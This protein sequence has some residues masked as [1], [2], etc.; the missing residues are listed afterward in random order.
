LSASP[1]PQPVYSV[2]GPLGS[3]EHIGVVLAV[4]RRVVEGASR[5]CLLDK[6]RPARALLVSP[7]IFSI[8]RPRPASPP[9]QP[10]HTPSRS[11]LTPSVRPSARLQSLSAFLLS[12]LKIPTG[13]VLPS[14]LIWQRTTAAEMF[15]ISQRLSNMQARGK[16]FD[17]MKKPKMH[18][19]PFTVMMK[20][21]I[22]PSVARDQ[23]CTD[24]WVQLVTLAFG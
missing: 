16:C 3:G 23:S 6:K 12:I 7:S 2:A 8:S 18:S 11:C 1:F 21:V 9:S 17:G 10:H 22:L 5:F 13:M 24:P 19:E 14:R 15:I 20:L 4:N